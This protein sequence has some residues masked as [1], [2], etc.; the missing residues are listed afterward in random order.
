VIHVSIGTAGVLELA[1]L[2]IAVAPTTAYLMVGERC[3]M[4]CAFCTQARSSS[5][6]DLAL[7]RVTW[8]LFP[9]PE[10]C[11]RLG[12]AERSGTL[13]RCCLQVTT[14]VDHVQKALDTVTQLRH[15]ISLPLSVAIYLRT[16]EQVEAFL[17]RGVDRIGLG[18]DA[19]CEC[20]F[21]RVKGPHW[22]S[23]VAL[24]EEAARRFP[25]RIA[26]HLVAGLGETEQEMV[27]RM[28]WAHQIGAGVSLFAFTPV[29]GTALA[30]WPQPALSVYRRLQAARWAIVRCGAQWEDFA[31]SDNGVLL[32][33]PRAT[34]CAS[35]E[36]AGMIDS[37]A[38]CTAGCPGCN[39]P[40]Y[41]ERPG[42][43]IYNYARPLTPAEAENACEQMGLAP[44]SRGTDKG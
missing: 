29:R 7:S 18:L 22:G 30:E 13:E 41:N 33:L 39:R 35:V 17:T 3:T 40:F 42:G 25:Q 38:F 36:G 8:P 10:V 37:E 2:P 11:E 15:A 34:T 9:L 31:F 21:R 26:V 14:C 4:D 6:S 16:V 1:A 32:D 28:L 23:M 19:A 5:A 27:E 20:V 12:Q 24:T 44:V 43:P